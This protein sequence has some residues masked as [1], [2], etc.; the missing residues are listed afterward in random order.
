MNKKKVSVFLIII[1][2]LLIVVGFVLNTNS[3]EKPKTDPV[4]GE[5]PPVDEDIANKTI[6]QI[7][8]KEK[9][10]KDVKNFTNKIFDSNVKQDD[11]TKLTYFV[12]NYNDIYYGKD[13]YFKHLNDNLSGVDDINKKRDQ[14]VSSLEKM[15]KDNFELKI[16]DYSVSQ[17]GAVVQ[18]VTFKS[19]YYT[20]FLLDYFSVVNKLTSYTKYANAVAPEDGKIDPQVVKDTYILNVKA[21]EIMS[22]HFSDY[23]NNEEYEEFS[24]IYRKESN[25]ISNE[26]FSFYKFI[27]GS[28][29]QHTNL[30]DANRN[31][32]VDAMIQEAINGG[33]L[34]VND[35]F[36]LK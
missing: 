10:E 36:T 15:I 34:D 21:L 5:T 22:P 26:Y 11:L 1:G 33:T 7:M 23:I 32:R 9:T 27:G 16:N 13:T 2:I 35:P 3:G 28:G 29:Y 31:A 12:I 17:D 25:V 18:N 14:Y 20:T 24:L 6:D 4:K 8:T 30:P 19:Y